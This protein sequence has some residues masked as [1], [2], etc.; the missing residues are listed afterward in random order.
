MFKAILV[1]IDTAQETSWR[2]ALPEAIEM[3]RASS[4]SLT[5]MTV[6]RGIKPLLEGIDPPIGTEQMMEEAQDNLADIISKV[7]H[8][9]IQIGREVRFGG[10][11]YEILDV[12][13]ARGADLILMASHRPSIKDY[14]IGP[15]AAF[16]AQHAKCSV[17]VLRKFDGDRK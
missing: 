7:P 5:V 9:S 6:V 14:F 8:G 10:I 4:G 17:L 16:V 1:P 2:Y 15:N 3:T 11:G 12:A 13:Q